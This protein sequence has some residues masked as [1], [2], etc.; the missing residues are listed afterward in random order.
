MMAYIMQLAAAQCPRNSTSCCPQGSL[1]PYAEQSNHPSTITISN[2]RVYETGQGTKGVVIASDIYG[3]F[4]GRSL[5]Y[6]KRLAKEGFHVF[7]PDLLHGTQLIHNGVPI[8]DFGT[9]LG[10]ITW[11]QTRRDVF[12]ILVPYMKTRGVTKFGIIGFCWGPR[13]ITRVCAENDIFSAGVSFHP[14]WEGFAIHGD[15]PYDLAAKIK[16]PQLFCTAGNDNA[17]FK[18]GGQFS[19]IL[20]TN[21]GD[22]LQLVDYP[23]MFHG[24]VNRTPMDDPKA[25]AQ[26]AD[27]I[28]R[29][30]KFLKE[31]L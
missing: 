2:L 18:A 20:K 7:Y 6:A 11:A 16:A 24:W 28:D 14:S 8:P 27:A 13:V 3:I 5:E 12:D 17:N 1:P 26:A 30:V 29:G 31:Y 21:L 19:E 22:K 9:K 4:G 25:V 23:D 15:N 10:Q